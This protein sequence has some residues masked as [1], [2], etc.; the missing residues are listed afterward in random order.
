MHGK[1]NGNLSQGCQHN[2]SNPVKG[3]LLCTARDFTGSGTK[4]RPGFAPDVTATTGSLRFL[5][6]ESS[7]QTPPSL[8]GQHQE[9]QQQQKREPDFRC[10]HNVSHC[11]RTAMVLFLFINIFIFITNMSM[12]T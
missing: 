9:Q 2:F 3:H 8:Q 12:T 1:K 11:D 5:L 10:H 4:K 7:T 6:N